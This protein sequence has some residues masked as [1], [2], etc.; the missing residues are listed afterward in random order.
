MKEN[1][2]PSLRG[3]LQKTLE[4]LGKVE[5]K[6]KAFTLKR[7]DFPPGMGYD[8]I[9]LAE[10]VADTCTCLETFFVRVSRTF[11]NHLEREKWH[12]SLLDNMLLEIPGIRKAVI[13]QEAYSLLRELMSF[14]HFKRYSFELEYDPDKMEFLEKKLK[15]LFPLIRDELTDYDSFLDEL[16]E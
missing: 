3:N 1:D 16:S 13:S 14:R 4:L 10:L 15:Q 5:E 11:E 6:Y 12:A 2:I 7:A 8:L 9:I